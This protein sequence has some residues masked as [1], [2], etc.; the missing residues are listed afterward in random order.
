MR[1]QIEVNTTLCIVT[2]CRQYD[3]TC[4]FTFLSVPLKLIGRLRREGKT[5]FLLCFQL[6]LLSIKRRDSTRVVICIIRNSRAIWPSCRNLAGIGKTVSFLFVSS[7]QLHLCTPCY[8]SVF[9]LSG[10]GVCHKPNSYS[11]C[12]PGDRHC[13][14]RCRRRWVADG[15]RLSTT[16]KT[17][18]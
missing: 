16:T 2:I 15:T 12:C 9:S 3:K 6:L 17:I 7:R 14:C 8:F 13:Q 4:T 11:R 18:G 5:V 10:Y 1:F